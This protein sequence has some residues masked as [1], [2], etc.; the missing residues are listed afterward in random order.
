[1]K[2]LMSIARDFAV[3]IVIMHQLNR[4]A[5]KRNNKEP[6][7]NDLAESIGVSQTAVMVMALYRPTYYD[8]E[9]ADTSTYLRVLKSRFVPAN[10]ARFVM[11]FDAARGC[12][13][14]VHH[15]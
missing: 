1:M 13:S 2:D 8:P 9:H 15:G 3:P 4:E 6:Q 7:L 5:T 14:E 11:V 12:Y 10:G